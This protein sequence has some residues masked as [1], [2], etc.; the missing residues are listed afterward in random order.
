MFR[1][2]RST[3]YRTSTESI[4]RNQYEQMRINEQM[5]AAKRVLK[6]SD[7]VVSSSLNQGSHRVLNELDQYSVNIGNNKTWLQQGMSSMSQISELLSQI[8]EKAE[9][10]ATGTYSSEQ[11]QIIAGFAASF[12][13]QIINIANVKVDNK[14]IFAGT[15]NNVQAASLDIWSETPAVIVDANGGSGRLYGQGTYTGLYSRDI[16]LTVAQAPP[17]TPPTAISP[18]NPL[19]LDYSYYDD[20]G[21]KK[22]GQVTLTGTGPGRGVDVGDGLQIYA[23]PNTTFVE[24]GTFV[25]E[26]GRHRGNNEA[27]FGNITWD[28]RQQYN[29][30]LD[31]FLRV[32]GYSGQE[33]MLALPS[34]RN[35]H[36]STGALQ[37]GGADSVLQQLGLEFTVGGPFQTTQGDQE[38]LTRRDYQF[39]VSA[40]PYPNEPPSPTNPVTVTY[41]YKDDS[42]TV[43]T[44]LPLTVTGA[45]PEHTVLLEPDDEGSGFYMVNA[46]FAS[47]ALAGTQ[48]FSL[49]S[50][51]SQPSL[52]NPMPLTYT[53][54]DPLTGQRLSDTV[55][56][57]K[58]GESLNLPAGYGVS[59]KVQAGVYNTGD[60]WQVESGY[61]NGGYHNLLDLIQGWE[62]ALQKDNTVQDYF[63]AVPGLPNRVDSK[64]DF[65]VAGDW[66]NLKAKGYEF[67]VGGLAQTNQTDQ[68]ILA[69]R[70]Y[71]F[72]I[73]P[74]YPGGP[75]S[76]L[77]PLVI[78][79]TYLDSSAT[80]QNAKITVT[81][82]GPDFAVMLE[83]PDDKTSFY[84]PNAEYFYDPAAAPFTFASG[85]DSSLAPS[86][87]NPMPVTY[88]Y[89]DEAGIRR[90]QTTLVTD[91]NSQVTLEPLDQSSV[92]SFSS[93]SRFQYGDSFN[94]T[95]QQYQQGQTYSQ[96]LLEEITALQSNL[97]KYTGDAG[98]KLNNL[99][100]RLQFMGD[101]VMRIDD[102]LVQLEEVDLPEITSRY[103]MLQLMYQAALQ[104]VNAMFSPSLANY[105]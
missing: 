103:A 1:V 60:S 23:D 92:L 25:L 30:L 86:P 78:N 68:A 52:T 85:Y 59:L 100:V 27:L 71:Q 13:E 50:N 41:T 29:Y 88:T 96:K 90:Y 62:D 53:Y 32:E 70:D 6:P 84:L 3:F 74:A 4:L 98:A 12:F 18:A 31:Q 28:N 19:V 81:G 69:A 22:E 39:T 24:G 77:N 26:A 80:L 48:G 101:D 9:Q 76:P 95:L 89:K 64:G 54:T 15:E 33:A 35:Y 47:L 56:I 38:L 40:A 20:Y 93:G 51:G 5:S 16:E 45:G 11:R 34:A 44:P 42:G 99:E 102:R 94:L 7:D 73:D 75:P 21:R 37:V 66:D 55:T 97:L 87:T 104:T 72:S 43:I 67:Y 46:S 2:S 91:L 79:Y 49:Y 83:P 14:Y 8:K 10:M 63:E 57:T 17:L 36:L 61:N 58:P 105:I 82:A 65:R